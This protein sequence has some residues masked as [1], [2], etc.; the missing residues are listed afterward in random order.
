LPPRP[1]TG[2]SCSNHAEQLWRSC[3]QA[4]DGGYDRNPSMSILCH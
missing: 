4:L 2:P 3:A 1:P